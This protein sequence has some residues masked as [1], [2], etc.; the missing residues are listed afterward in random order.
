MKVTVADIM[1]LHNFNGLKLIAGNNGLDRNITKCGILDYEYDTSVKIKHLYNNFE[2]GQFVLTS[3]LFAKDN[4]FLVFDALKHLINKNVSGLVIKNVF[5]IPLSERLLSYA[6]SKKFPIFLMKDRLYFED[7]IVSITDCIRNLSS[8]HFGEGEVDRMLHGSLDEKALIKQIQQINCSFQPNHLVIYFRLKNAI[9][10]DLY[11]ESLKQYKNSA[12]YSPSDSLFRYRNGLMFIHSCESFRSNH[13]TDLITDY[14]SLIAQ[15]PS[16]YYIGIS[17]L[18]YSLSE[19]KYAIEESIHAAVM[20]SNETKNY[21][22]Y[23]DLGVYQL[24]IPFIEERHFINFSNGI[25][26]Q[27]LDYDVENKT[28]LTTTAVQFISCK[29]NIQQLANFLSQHENTIRYRLDKIKMVTGLD[30]RQPEQYEQL[31][32]AVKIHICQNRLEEF[33]HYE[34]I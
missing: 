10:A 31:S 4:E 6:D 23:Q 9:S 8:I 1:N 3:L 21:Q 20:H 19:M 11:I 30:S 25:M 2:E 28:N 27:L 32:M 17:S 12:L 14:I 29:G 5:Q 18:H 34:V 24:L 26:E 33:Y 16:D 22:L 15:D 7:L 13:I